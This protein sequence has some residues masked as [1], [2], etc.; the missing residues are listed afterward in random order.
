MSLKVAIN[1]FNRVASNIEIESLLSNEAMNAVT[2]ISTVGAID[3]QA[4]AG[5]VTKAEL[6]ST[7]GAGDLVEKIDMSLGQS[8][9]GGTSILPEEFY[10][11][12][13]VLAA[14]PGAVTE[15]EKEDFLAY[16]DQVLY[17]VTVINDR[18]FTCLVFDDLTD[19]IG[20]EDFILEINSKLASWFSVA[21]VKANEITD[22][23]DTMRDECTNIYFIQSYEESEGVF[24]DYADG[25]LA[26]RIIYQGV[27]NT[28]GVAKELTGITAY[29][30]SF[31][32]GEV[33]KMSTTEAAAWITAGF[34]IY[35]RYINN[36]NETSGVVSPV[37]EDFT[38]IWALYKVSSDLSQDLH[39]LRHNE[40]VLT[41]QDEGT[42][43][44]A[45]VDRM[46]KLKRPV[47]QGGLGIIYDYK[48]TSANLDYTLE[49]NQGRFGFNV[50][51]SLF[52]EGKNFTLNITGY[53]DLTQFDIE[54]AA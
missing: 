42:V 40:E 11:S 21:F 16:L 22:I 1:N 6:T 49:S 2:F 18:Q 25:A 51:V 3:T 31:V 14:T 30:P 44:A 26:G 48:V 13:T 19:I 5:S 47:S 36:K 54:Q 24:E 10:V 8:T 28:Q 23:T 4:F 29:K 35:T 20:D 52:Q 46:A 12:G 43:R 37:G 7:L 34:N 50:E 32:G 27:G 33:G 53:K 38:N 15:Q 9:A 45:I 39:D 17:D 41:V